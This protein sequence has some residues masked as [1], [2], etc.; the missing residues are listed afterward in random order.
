VTGQSRNDR[1]DRLGQGDVA[2]QHRHALLLSRALRSLGLPSPVQL[3]VRLRVALLTLPLFQRGAA[4]LLPGHSDI[5]PG[6]CIGSDLS[7]GGLSVFGSH[8]PV[9][10]GRKQAHEALT[11]RRQRDT[12]GGVDDLPDRSMSAVQ[13]GQLRSKR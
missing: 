8:V 5:D 4:R 13:L 2:A 6:V 1:A 11:Q 9:L 12:R 3:L 10:T 7:K